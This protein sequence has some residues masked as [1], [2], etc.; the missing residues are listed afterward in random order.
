M[1]VE[2]MYDIDQKVKTCFGDVGIVR[3]VSLDDTREKK[4]WVMRSQ[5][6]AWFKETDLEPV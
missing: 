5:D 2:F 6:S 1:H 3:G 4:Y